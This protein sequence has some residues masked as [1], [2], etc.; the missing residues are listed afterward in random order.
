MNIT[1]YLPLFK[2]PL[3]TLRWM[4]HANRTHLPFPILIG[5][6]GDEP[7]VR[8][9]LEDASNFPNL[10]YQYLKYDDHSYDAFYAKNANVLSKVKTPYVVWADNDDFPI[11]AGLKQAAL[12]MDE[13]D[14]VSSA[15]GWIGTFALFETDAK[16]GSE[17]VTGE[18]Y[19]YTLFHKAQPLMEDTALDRV[20]EYLLK[21]SDVFNTLHKTECFHRAQKRV[22]EAGFITIDMFE[23]F[24]V[25]DMLAHGKCR[26]EGSNVLVFRQIGTS[27]VAAGSLPLKDR[28][29]QQDWKTDLETFVKKIA[30]AIVEADAMPRELAEA[31]LADIYAER[32]RG[33][34]K[35]NSEHAEPKSALRALLIKAA[36]LALRLKPV[37]ALRA[38]HQRR[39]LLDELSTN[40]ASAGFIA[41]VDREMF[42]FEKTLTGPDFPEFVRRVA[43]QLLK[44]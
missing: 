42:E 16:A 41:E 2:R 27:V 24:T 28:I 6:G 22:G 11:V 10:E 44:Q 17:Q 5:D 9:I 7:E 35:H 19:R 40:G 25:S 33:R 37:R 31:A 4:W 34:L 15:G 26:Y 18:M 39:A 38:R 12:H 13:D 29:E 43:P 32:N 36:R 3:H 8:K 21:P 14:K 30:L 20:R 23:D 1:I